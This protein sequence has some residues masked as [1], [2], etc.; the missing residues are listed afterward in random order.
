MSRLRSITSRSITLAFVLLCGTAARA[1]GQ[2]VREAQLS[3]SATVIA[4][5]PRVDHAEVSALS[6]RATAE[7][8]IE[9]QE[10]VT[11]GSSEESILSIV[12]RVDGVTV[13]I[14]AADDRMTPVGPGGVRVARTT[15]GRELSLPLTLRLRSA[16]PELL[17]T[18]SRAP[19]LLLVDSASR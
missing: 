17:S 4:S 19:V 13:E 7:G 1:G 18:A 15:G 14:V 8:E 6:S 5:A 10:L 11:A 3:V 9:V 12:A 2:Q 16:N